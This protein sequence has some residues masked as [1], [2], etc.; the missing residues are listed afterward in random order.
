MLQCPRPPIHT[1]DCSSLPTIHKLQQQHKITAQ[2]EEEKQHLFSRTLPFFYHFFF[3]LPLPL[4]FLCL[5][6]KRRFLFA[7]VICCAHVCASVFA[8]VCDCVSFLFACAFLQNFRQYSINT[9]RCFSLLFVL[10]ATSPSP[11][12]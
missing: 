2:N 8:S 3:V 4:K 9:F 10:S 11:A 6:F 12:A 1:H 5:H 7:F